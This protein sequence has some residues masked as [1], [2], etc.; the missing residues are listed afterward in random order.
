MQ[1]KLLLSAE[2]RILF[3]IKRQTSKQQDTPNFRSTILNKEINTSECGK[4]IQMT[5]GYFLRPGG[6]LVTHP[7]VLHFPRWRLSQFPTLRTFRMSNSLP[8][9]T[10]PSLIPVGCPPLHP[11]LGQTIDRC[12]KHEQKCKNALQIMS[13]ATYLL[14]KLPCEQRLHFRGM[15]WRAK[16]SLCRQ[17]FKSVQKSGRIN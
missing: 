11:I 10:S 9:C 1:V 15:S 14:T 17:P 2:G 5:T 6:P 8:T 3:V 13:L 16:S 7:Q 4:L 12:I